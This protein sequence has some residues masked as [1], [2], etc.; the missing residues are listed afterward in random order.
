MENRS[1][2]T[3]PA[4]SPAKVKGRDFEPPPRTTD[5]DQDDKAA[6]PPPCDFDPASSAPPR[7][8]KPGH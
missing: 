2:A 7:S 1:D 5:I 4:K 8:G 3:V 6:G